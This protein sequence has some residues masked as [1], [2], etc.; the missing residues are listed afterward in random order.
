LEKWIRE[1]L[2]DV[3]LGDVIKKWSGTIMQSDDDIALIG[4]AYPD[5]KSNIRVCTADGGHGI[6]HAAVASI[7]ILDQITGRQNSWVD[8]YCPYRHLLKAEGKQPGHL[9][10]VIPPIERSR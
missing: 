7:I 8:I 1:L 6:L 10:R 9:T 4:K 5:P 2:P 3:P